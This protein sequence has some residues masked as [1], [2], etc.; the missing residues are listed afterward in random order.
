[1]AVNQE[2]LEFV[3]D[4]ER[5]LFAAARLGEDARA[6]LSSHPVGRLLHHRAK[7]MI[8]QA[9]VDALEVDP[10]GWRG[11]FQARRKLRQ[12]RQRAAVG[13]AFINFVADAI[14]DGDDAARQLDD[15]RKP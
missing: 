6:F 1:M 12:I 2:T 11:W 7:Q 5:E 4:T 15:Y 14:I 3:D 8:A 9:E 13:R 10:D